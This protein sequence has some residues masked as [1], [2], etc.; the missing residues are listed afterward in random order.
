MAS[1]DFDRCNARK[2]GWRTTVARKLGLLKG[3]TKGSP[4]YDAALR[5]KRVEQAVPVIE[6]GPKASQSVSKYPASYCSQAAGA[7]TDHPGVGRC[8]YGHGGKTPF[9]PAN[10]AYKHGR[11]STMSRV[12]RAIRARPDAV[13]LD[14][15]L[16]A[17][18]Y[19]LSE[20]YHDLDRGGDHTDSL[21]EICERTSEM[22]RTAITEHDMAVRTGGAA[23]AD[24]LDKSRTRMKLAVDVLD[25]AL[26]DSKHVDETWTK[27]ERLWESHRKLSGQKTLS[28]VR[29]QDVITRQFAEA[30]AAMIAKTALDVLDE[31]VSEELKGAAGSTLMARVQNQLRGF[32]PPPRMIEQ[33]ED[34]ALEA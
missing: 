7:R 20:L 21:R 6:P 3:L 24:M 29:S 31:Y 16:K 27:I 8:G 18:E 30:R 32:E 33:P 11:D 22:V 13:A 34:R 19:R 17:V 25:T 2:T 26:G 4:E 14:T 15:D 5:D 28:D 9:G 10:P 12:E 23:G 1:K